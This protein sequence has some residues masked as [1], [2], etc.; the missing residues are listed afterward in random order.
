MWRLLWVVRVIATATCFS[1]TEPSTWLATFVF[2]GD[3]P[4]QN[5]HQNEH[6]EPGL[7]TALFH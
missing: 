4:T 5:P 1:T 6:H 3:F 2:L 7:E